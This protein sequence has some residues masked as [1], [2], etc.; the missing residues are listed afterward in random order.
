MALRGVLI[1]WLMEAKKSLFALLAASAASLAGIEFMEREKIGEHARELGE[2]IMKRLREM[3][4]EHP[5][6]GDVRGMGLMIGVEFVKPDKAPDP[7]LRDKILVEGFKQ[8]IVLLPSGDSVIRFSPPLVLTEEEA[9]K[10]L[11]SF[12]E[13]LRTAEKR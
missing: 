8:G 3:Q 2:H 13:A 4:Q 7:T 12:E 1:S 5:V 11:D 9:D 10:G 6:M